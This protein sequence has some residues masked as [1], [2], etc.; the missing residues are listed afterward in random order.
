MKRTK[1]Y[2]ILLIAVLIPCMVFLTA[3]NGIDF[4]SKD[5]TVDNSTYVAELENEN[6][7]L[8]ELVDFY[9]AQ[10]TY[11]NEQSVIFQ[12][13]VITLQNQ[14]A[15]LIAANQDGAALLELIESK[16][17]EIEALKLQVANLREEIATLNSGTGNEISELQAQVTTLQNDIVRIT[18]EKNAEIESLTQSKNAQIESL[19]SQIV[20]LEQTIATMTEDALA[21]QS[22]IDE[23]SANDSAKASQIEALTSLING[24]L[25]TIAG[26]ENTITQLQ[27]LVAYLESTIPDIALRAEF[28]VSYEVDGGI[29][30]AQLVRDG[31]FPA[32]PSVPSGN[33]IFDG[34]SLDGINAVNPTTVKITKDIKFYA[35]IKCQV[36]FMA[37]DEQYGATQTVKQ[38]NSPSVPNDPTSNKT[39]YRFVGWTLNGVDTINLTG[40]GVLQNITLFAKFELLTVSPAVDSWT[41]IGLVSDAI[42]NGADPASFNYYLGD[43]KIVTLST[44][45]TVTLQILGFRHDDKSDGTGKAGITW[46]MKNLLATTYAMNPT[47]TNVNGWDGC[48]MRNTTLPD[49]LATMPSDLQ[50][51][52]KTVN[53]K[54][55]AG[56]ISTV[57]KTSADKLFLFSQVEINNTTSNGLSGEGVQYQYWKTVKDGT[58]AVNYRKYL[59]DGAGAEQYFF[60]RSPHT[61][62]SDSFYYVGSG[63]FARR[64]GGSFGVCFGFAV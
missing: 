12:G 17:A 29:W 25:S 9:I 64:V 43:E 27:N 36:T 52:I 18:N 6:A 30:D 20:D 39:G 32:L 24:Y 40:Y 54:A 56:N 42:A 46:G 21:S 48:A 4:S 23:L 14:I 62:Y 8:K 35:L 57:I 63:G 33:W 10:S 5:K 55:T 28:L 1:F 2:K 15:A 26:Y 61:S 34:W 13:Q 49:I 22:R 45:E 37:N 31:N 19:Q 41:T 11:W 44:N 53:K 16:D 47:S 3:C 60:T 58:L 51:V 59:S 50:S 38:G 7:E